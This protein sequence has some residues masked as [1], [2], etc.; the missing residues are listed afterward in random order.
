[1]QQQMH[2]NPLINFALLLF[3]HLNHQQINHHHQTH[4]ECITKLSSMEKFLIRDPRQRIFI[5]TKQIE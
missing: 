4:T 5:Q 2:N 3:T 1:M